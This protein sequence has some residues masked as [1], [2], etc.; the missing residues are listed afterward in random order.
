MQH[1]FK[2]LTILFVHAQQ[3]ERKHNGDH[4]QHRSASGQPLSEQKEKRQSNQDAAAKANE[5]SFGQ[6]KNHFGFDL[7]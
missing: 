5:L 3:E 4:G 6:V 7:S 2:R 1:L